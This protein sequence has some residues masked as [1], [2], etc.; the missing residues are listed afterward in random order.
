MC[1]TESAVRRR[2]AMELSAIRKELILCAARTVRHPRPML[3]ERP[4][5]RDV[6]YNRPGSHQLAYS[7]PPIPGSW[8]WIRLNPWTSVP[9]PHLV[10]RSA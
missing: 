2:L 4:L 10:Q 3:C 8:R 1:K 9:A 6:D 7:R 5:V